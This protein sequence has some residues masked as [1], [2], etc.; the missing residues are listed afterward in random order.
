M[1]IWVWIPF[2]CQATLF[3]FAVLRVDNFHK[4]YEPHSDACRSRKKAWSLKMT[5]TCKRPIQK[6]RKNIMSYLTISVSSL[7]LNK[8]AYDFCRRCNS[9]IRM[10]MPSIT[11]KRKQKCSTEGNSFYWLVWAEDG[12][13]GSA[14]WIFWKNGLFFWTGTSRYRVILPW[15]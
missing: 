13:Q 8:A 7:D 6:F 2:S 10:N 11:P 15:M 3:S 5:L 9:A 14:T 12:G 1:A 4:R